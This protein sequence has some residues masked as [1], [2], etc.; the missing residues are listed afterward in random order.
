MKKAV[1]FETIERQELGEL[2]D[3]AFNTLETPANSTDLA[4]AQSYYE[5]LRAD[6]YEEWLKNPAKFSQKSNT[7][8]EDSRSRKMRGR[9]R[10][11]RQSAE[12]F[13][14]EM[15][16]IGLI[17]KIKAARE[18]LDDETLYASGLR[19]D[20]F[21]AKFA[22]RDGS[23]KK[24]LIDR[25]RKEKYAVGSVSFDDRVSSQRRRYQEQTRRE[26]ARLNIRAKQ[27]S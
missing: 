5:D 14:L 19:T 12:K 15:S 3:Y 26:A 4:L 24:D 20:G 22:R 9:A 21:F 8:T 11:L 13:I 1:D 6:L 10:H 17:R 25:E 18:S 27:I 16:D 7:S 2:Y 23:R